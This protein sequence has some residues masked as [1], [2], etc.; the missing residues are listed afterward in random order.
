MLLFDCCQVVDGSL[1]ALLS[2]VWRPRHT[3]ADR[4][5]CASTRSRSADRPRRLGM[6]RPWSSY[7]HE[8]LSS[9]R[10]V[11]SGA[12]PVASRAVVWRKSQLYTAV[13]IASQFTYFLFTQYMG[14]PWKVHIL[15]GL[16]LGL[17]TLLNDEV[18]LR[19]KGQKSSLQGM[20]MQR[21]RFYV[22]LREK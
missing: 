9:S 11:S 13:L 4:T 15:W 6:W 14:T 2:D 10:A 5:M 21:K 22:C 7:R 17:L 18:T 12:R 1:A 20:K 3:Q 8:R 19:W 16:V